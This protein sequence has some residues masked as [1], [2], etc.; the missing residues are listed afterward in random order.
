ML[1]LK[2]RIQYTLIVTVQVFNSDGFTEFKVA[3]ISL[4][5]FGRREIYLAENVR[6][7]QTHQIDVEHRC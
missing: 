2:V 5:A 4:A 3:D 6:T 1:P 7:T